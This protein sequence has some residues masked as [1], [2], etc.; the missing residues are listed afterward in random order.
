LLDFSRKVVL[1]AQ[2]RKLR[3]VECLDIATKTGTIVIVGGTRRSAELSLSDLD[4]TEMRQAK[5]GQF[6]I[7]N[8][9]RA[10]ANISTVYLQTPTRE[11]FQEEWQAL[12]SSG[13]G[14]RGIYNREAANSTKPARRKQATY[15]CNP[16]AEIQLQPLQTCNLSEVV[17]RSGD[18]EE[19]LARKVRIATIIGTIQSTFIDFHYLR[20]AWREH[21]AEERLLGVS[22]TGQMDCPAWRDAD[23]MRRLRQVAIDTNR[24]Y[25]AR[26][27][28]NESA[29]ITTVKPSGTASCVVDAASGIHPRYAPFY[30]RRV[31]ISAHDPLFHLVRDAGAP[32]F[33]ETGQDAATATTWVVEF[34]VASPPGAIT[35][36]DLTALQ[37]LEF[38]L[39]VKESWA[40]HSV[41][42]TCYVE[43]HEWDEVGKW[44]YEHFSRI[45]GLSFLPKDNH[46]YPLA[47]YQQI[48]EDEYTKLA[49]AFPTIDYGLLKYYEDTDMTE[50][51]QTLACV[52]GNCEA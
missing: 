48:T 8:G 3:S 52:A 37:Q 40:E 26:F 18:T 12:A 6:W 45:S 43:D 44:V 47:P 30:I 33:P 28:I 50:G 19:S 49:E 31:R 1:G 29:A 14:E 20:P 25:A 51:A 4:D 46:I 23:T 11:Q 36:R 24:E 17:A 7:E 21:G 35:R 2:G 38:W 16:C 42:C 5:S 32:V 15:G 27:G 22:C 41:S 39:T 34:P 13:T 10:M 9:Q